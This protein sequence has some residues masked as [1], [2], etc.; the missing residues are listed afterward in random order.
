MILSYLIYI[1][2]LRGRNPS[3]MW[4]TFPFMLVVLRL[5]P[6]YAWIVTQQLNASFHSTFKF[7]LRW[8][9]L[10]LVNN[11]TIYP[12]LNLHEIMLC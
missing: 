7:R 10:F 8:P 4:R 2:E 12:F 11:V 9:V 1:T 5:W 3:A 6:Q